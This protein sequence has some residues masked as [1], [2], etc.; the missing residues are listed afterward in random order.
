MDTV[1]E[2]M[3]LAPPKMSFASSSKPTRV[4]ARDGDVVRTPSAFE[5]DQTDSPRFER[6]RR[7]EKE[8]DMPA[9]DFSDLR[10]RRTTQKDDGDGWT[11]VSRT[12][13]KSFGQ[14]E[15][16]RFRRDFRAD[17][18][19]KGTTPW[20]RDRKYEGFGKD[21]DREQR[22]RPRRDESSW[23][24]DDRGDRNRDNYHRENKYG[25]RIEKDPEWM[26][27]SVDGKETKGVHSMEDFQKWKERMKA[28]SGGTRITTTDNDKKRDDDVLS[29]PVQDPETLPLSDLKEDN[30]SKDSSDEGVPLNRGRFSAPY[31]M[32]SILTAM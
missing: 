16:E 31:G 30:S 11:N 3:V 9:R 6:F 22:P 19:K 14:E 10:A 32:L 25:G 27:S 24:L 18:E 21:R 4:A 15:G 7:E 26:D 12:P 8:K 1:P 2:D 5:D 29:K 28:T 17:N 20:D 23:L 13:R